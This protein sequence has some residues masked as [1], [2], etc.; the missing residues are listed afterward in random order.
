MY[1]GPNRS[2]PQGEEEGMMTGSRITFYIIEWV[3]LLIATMGAL[4]WGLVGLF[5]YSATSPGFEGYG[6]V[7]GIAQG[8]STTGSFG[9]LTG[10]SRVVY[11]IVGIAGLITL[12]VVIEMVRRRLSPWRL[13][14][15]VAVLLTALGAINWGL[16]GLFKYDAVAEA[17]GRSFGALFTG[18]RVL[19]TV[20]GVAGLIS[21]GG[22]VDLFGVYFV[23]SAKR[24]LRL[25]T[26]EPVAEE[27]K[28]A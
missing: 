7:P 24:P 22:L 6:R 8:I 3:S 27:R 28:A 23:A 16:I 19:Y 14:S 25:V 20:I 11:T 2:H 17:F 4:A 18:D 13:V 21:V 5:K 15:I 1:Q 26:P 9:V 12:G 10:G